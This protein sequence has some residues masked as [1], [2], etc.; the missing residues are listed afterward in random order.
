MSPL[1]FSMASVYIIKN[2]VNGKVYIGKTST[3]TVEERFLQHINDS[4]K[5]KYQSKRLLYAAMKK[6][7]IDNFC[8]EELEG[9]L[10]DDE[11]C[12]QEVYYINKYRSFVKFDDC[13]GYNMTPGG[14]G[15]R[16]ADYDRIIEVFVKNNYDKKKTAEELHCTRRTVLRACKERGL[17]SNQKGLPKQVDLYEKSTMKLLKTFDSI[18]GARTFINHNFS[19]K[20][21]RLREK[22]SLEVEGYLFVVKRKDKTNGRRKNKVSIGS[23]WRKNY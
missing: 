4:K 1:L 3:R 6:Y 23:D 8:V 16:Y 22:D 14:D 21:H 15:H 9:G 11:A 12:K 13:N 5:K 20:G 2:K 10:T 17:E 18:K 19:T 7:G